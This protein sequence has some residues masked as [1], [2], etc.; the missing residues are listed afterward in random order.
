MAGPATLKQ[1]VIWALTLAIALF[2][3]VQAVV[4]YLVLDQQEDRIVDQIVMTEAERLVHRLEAGEMVWTGSDILLGPSLHAWVGTNGD[5]P[6]VLARLGPGQY[7]LNTEGQVWHVAVA[8]STKGRVYLRYDATDNEHRVYEFGAILLGLWLAC[9]LL[10]Y[11]TARALA[12]RVV[13]SMV[14]VTDRIESWAP[15]SPGMKVVRSDEAGRLIEAFNR[16][17]DKVDQSIAQEREF[18]A[19]LSHEIR[20]P[21]TSIRT[22]AELIALEAEPSAQAGLRLTRIVNAVDEIA[23]T[24]ETARAIS[25]AQ[26]GPRTEVSLRACLDD[27]W[28]GL[29]ERAH[30]AGLVLANDVP[31]TAVPRLDRYGL[32]IVLRNLV[33][34]AIDHAAPATL[35]ASWTG[36]CLALADNGPGIPASDL[37]FVFE[38]YYSGRL[39]DS[40]MPVA[41]AAGVQRGLGLAIAKRVCDIQGWRLTVTS[42][43]DELHRGTRFLLCF[44]EGATLAAS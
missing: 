40:Q 18:S 31:E 16:M 10:G 9:T 39:R 32:L 17:Q 27:A 24:L 37:P 12:G 35:T 21:L 20:T 13:G 42:S 43:T 19:N 41:D 15:G 36:E 29:A 2:V 7:Q 5:V 22:D 3:G 33:R 28:S 30:R 26:A 25:S 14:E 8:D 1:R 34:N 4:A 23:S 11:W 38:R 44:G 6:R